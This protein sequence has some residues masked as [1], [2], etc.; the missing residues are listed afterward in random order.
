MI[1]CLVRKE[2]GEAKK[3]KWFDNKIRNIKTSN[4]YLINKITE[5]EPI[6]FEVLLCMSLVSLSV[7][8]QFS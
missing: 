5:N 7:V 2:N 4:L 6:V 1:I 8:E 3:K